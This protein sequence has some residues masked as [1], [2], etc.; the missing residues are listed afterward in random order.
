MSERT[1]RV[2]GM[3]RESRTPPHQQWPMVLFP[4][5]P[6][7]PAR[8]LARSLTG[9]PV[10]RLAPGIACL[11]SCSSYACVHACMHVRLLVRLAAAWFTLP[12]LAQALFPSLARSFPLSLSPFPGGA[13]Q[14]QCLPGYCCYCFCLPS[15]VSSFLPRWFAC[16]VYGPSNLKN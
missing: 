2:K 1:S 13:S 8:S 11:S 5:I 15:V 4:L 3:Q 12:P 6:I 14:V 16:S 9:R 10:G 7:L